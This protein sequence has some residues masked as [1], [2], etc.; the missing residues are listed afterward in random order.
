[1]V[2]KE[3]V[4]HDE[5]RS[6]GALVGP[7]Y[8]ADEQP[9]RARG[10]SVEGPLVIGYS[11]FAGPGGAGR[12]ELKQQATLIARACQ[13]RGLRLLEVVAEREPANGKGLGRPGL[14]Y[15]LERI[16][17]RQASGLVVTE[18]S[19]LTRSAPDLGA[20]IQRLD[21]CEARLIADAHALDTED[22]NGR[23]FAALL[24]EIAQ[25][26]RERISRRT[27]KGLEA[28]RRQGRPTGR[29]AVTDNPDLSEWITQMRSRGMTLQAIADV[30]N[31]HGVPTVRG[32]AKWRHSS[33]QATI[34]YRRRLTSSTLDDEQQ[35]A[36]QR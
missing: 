20:I 19:R 30:L 9:A 18:L 27:R 5:R 3:S 25:W 6:L 33:V 23:R 35:H 31:E 17:D 21:E 32:G 1:M 26:E 2:G 8:R 11:S 14:D 4:V 34:G 36:Q 12:A 10:S 22:P 7:R 13:R 15:A 24:V 28:A 29:A 16:C